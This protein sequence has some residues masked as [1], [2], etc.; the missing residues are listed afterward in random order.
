VAIATDS[1]VFW[2]LF[3]VPGVVLGNGD[4]LLRLV[5]YKAVLEQLSCRMEGTNVSW[6]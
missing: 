1:Q 2:L 3:T 5:P 6:F 4:M